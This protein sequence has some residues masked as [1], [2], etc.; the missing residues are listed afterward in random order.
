MLLLVNTPEVSLMNATAVCLVI[1]AA[2]M[3][4]GGK[5]GK[6]AFVPP[7]KQFIFTV[8]AVPAMENL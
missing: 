7:R 2:N 1:Q 8:A 5:R 6:T 4:E 3:A